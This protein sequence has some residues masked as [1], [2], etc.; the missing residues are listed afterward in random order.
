[1]SLN[2]R[3]ALALSAAGI[4]SLTVP[5]PAHASGGGRSVMT[6]FPEPE[7]NRRIRAIEGLCWK[8]DC[9]RRALLFALDEYRAYQTELR[10]GDPDAPPA[11][12]DDERMRALSSQI[13]ML[14]NI[15]AL[16]YF[17]P[18]PDRLFREMCGCLSGGPYFMQVPPDDS[19]IALDDLL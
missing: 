12:L 4:T 17:R 7:I 2:R 9:M 15:V 14:Q 8:A 10:N 16:T 13:G 11:R 1:M 5:L 18:G 19:L 3:D 6:C